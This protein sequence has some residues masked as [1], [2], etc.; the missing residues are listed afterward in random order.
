VVVHER[1]RGQS[2]WTVH[3]RAIV[4]EQQTQPVISVFLNHGCIFDA[5]CT[6]QARNELSCVLAVLTRSV[7]SVDGV[8]WRTSRAWR[9]MLFLASLNATHVCT[10]ASEGNCSKC[11]ALSAR[12]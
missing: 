11:C 2:V 5:V 7:Y 4:I 9:S 1:E 10:N 3:V 6:K 12:V 8:T